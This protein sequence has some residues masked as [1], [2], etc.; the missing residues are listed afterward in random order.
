M[1]RRAMF[2]V[3]G[4]LVGL[5]TVAG[6]RPASAATPRCTGEGWRYFMQSP[7]VPYPDVD[8]YFPAHSPS[9]AAYVNYGTPESPY[10]IHVGDGFWSCSLVQGSTGEGV[11]VLQHEINVCYGG[12]AGPALVEDGQFGAKTRAALVKVQQY[13]GIGADGEYGPQTARTMWH[14]WRQLVDPFAAGCATMGQAGWPGNSG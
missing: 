7:G 3:V 13:H 12:I 10:W 4:L 9:T 14:R 1:R 5:V 11:R 6:A 8:I 2:V